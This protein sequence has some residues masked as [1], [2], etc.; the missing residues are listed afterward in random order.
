MCAIQDAL[1]S[2]KELELAGELVRSRSQ[3]CP[4]SLVRDQQLMSRYGGGRHPLTGYFYH[5][6]IVNN[7]Q[8]KGYP[9][10]PKIGSS[11]GEP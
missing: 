9:T 1:L 4:P 11:F 10:T 3:L 6:P 8:L 7:K 2:R 5:L